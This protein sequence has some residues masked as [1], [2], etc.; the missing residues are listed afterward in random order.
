MTLQAFGYGDKYGIGYGLYNEATFEFRPV[1]V[2]S[3]FEF[4]ID[5]T[6]VAWFDGEATSGNFANS[7]PTGNTTTTNVMEIKPDTSNNRI[8]FIFDGVTK[9]FIDSTG[10]NEGAP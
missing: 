5:G 1:F 2:G 10:T 7:V 6:A 8:L 4:K 3:Y 9:G